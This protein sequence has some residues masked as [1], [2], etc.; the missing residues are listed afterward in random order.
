VPD[1]AAVEEAKMQIKNLAWWDKAKAAG[2]DLPASPEVY[3]IHPISFIEQLDKLPLNVEL[4]IT[5]FAQWPKKPEALNGVDV[6]PYHKEVGFND[7]DYNKYQAYDQYFHALNASQGGTHSRF[8]F[9]VNG[10]VKM[11]GYMLEAA[12]PSSQVAGSDQRIIPGKYS[13]IDNPGSKGDFRLVKSTKEA[14]DELFGNR[15]LVNIHI[16]NFPKDI[17]GCFAPGAKDLTMNKGQD[18]EYPYVIGSENQYNRLKDLI[19]E[20]TRQQTIPSYDGSE[21]IYNTTLY[22]GL[23]VLIKE[24]F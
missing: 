9:I 12:G 16:A 3:H 1:E 19:I 6:V 10:S 20:H 23:T 24:E 18:N 5:R 2:A 15:S 22:T 14:A 13:L 8:K 4:I 17:E 21:S 11:T 7:P